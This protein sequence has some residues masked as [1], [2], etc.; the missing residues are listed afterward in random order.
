MAIDLYAELSRLTRALED[1]GIDH[2]LVGALALAL[3]GAPRATS[4]IDLLVRPDDVDAAL[5]VAKEEG[6][7]FEAPRLRFEDG[8]VL[9]R[10]TMIEREDPHDTLTVD[11]LL[12]GGNLEEVWESRR[13][14][15]TDFGDLWTISRDA[16][17]RMKTL[18]GREQ[19]L[20]DLRRLERMDR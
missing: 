1:A 14:I 15:E 4:D 17:I 16:L 8:Q 20:A 19:D 9:R 11:F 18:A 10:A 2:A 3:H 6:F 5:A 13:R 12:V 7:R